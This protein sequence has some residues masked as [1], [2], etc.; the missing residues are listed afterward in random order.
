[1]SPTRHRYKKLL[2]FTIV[3]ALM[4]IILGAYTRLSDAGL[5]CPDWPGCY[6]EL[7]GVP[8]THENT[9]FE[10]PLEASKAWKEMIHR[11]LAGT[12]GL[13]I[14][15]IFIFS[16]IKKRELQ[17]SPLLPTVLLL[18]VIF[19]ALLGMWTVT[20]LLSPVIVTA[21]LVGGFTTLSL[22]WILLLNQSRDISGPPPNTS[23]GLRFWAGLGLILLILQILLG[24]WTST[25]YA[26]LACGTDFPTCMKQW[27][28]VMNFDKAFQFV[29]ESGVDYEFGV[30]DSPARTAIQV[31]HRIGALTL[32]I[33]ML[34]LFALL[35]T[36]QKRFAGMAWALLSLLTLQISLGIFNVVMGL[37]LSVAVGHNLVAALL[38]LTLIMINHRAWRSE[39]SQY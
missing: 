20:M 9:G 32:T 6:G 21:H 10:R 22:T 24:G 31:L 3:L 36:Q 29:H 2:Q 30:L 37:P 28:P 39:Q 1:M 4:V 14:L 26:A 34:G 25:N 16:I 8:E 38:L 33:Y 12:L 15:G 35:L 27:W 5:G 17:Q 13:A 23:G 11:Y 7:I 18:T 19:Q